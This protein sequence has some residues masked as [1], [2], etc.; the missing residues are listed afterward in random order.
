MSS[1]IQLSFLSI[2][3]QPKQKTIGHKTVSQAVSQAVS[4]P[5]KH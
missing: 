4:Q 1:T 2:L 3:S 5:L